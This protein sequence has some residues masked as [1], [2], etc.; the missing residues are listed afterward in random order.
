MA[1]VPHAGVMQQLQGTH[2]LTSD[3][4]LRNAPGTP[5]RT[6][7]LLLH[8][9][10]VQHAWSKACFAK[11]S[12]LDIS[13][14]VLV[15]LPSPQMPHIGWFDR[16]TLQSCGLPHLFQPFLFFFFKEDTTSPGLREVSASALHSP[17]FP[18]QPPARRKRYTITPGH[19]KWDHFNLTYKYALAV[20]FFVLL[21][22]W[23]SIM[24]LPILLSVTG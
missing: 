3:P 24:K 18:P 1:A 20:T 7:L 10:F 13:E 9:D 11:S 8:P 17:A 6:A 23:I 19:L 15:V 5:H 4:A 2:R 22:A 14:G 16:Y 12:V 21:Q